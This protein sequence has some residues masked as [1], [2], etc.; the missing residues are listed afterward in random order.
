MN[1]YEI[2]RKDRA[3]SESNAIKILEKGSF[4]TLSTIGADGYPYGIP[5]NYVYNDGKIY[6]HC[7][8]NTG[9]KQDNLRF[10]GK[11]SFSVVTKSEIVPQELT[12]SYESAVVFGTASKI[13]FDKEKALWL[14]A[15]KYSPQ[16]IEES[17]SCIKNEFE[18]TDV[19]MIEI[20]KLTA[21][22]NI[23]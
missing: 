16:F 4:G 18:H 15:K 14:L 8:K 12:T 7:A 6:F 22:S 23:K 5:I 1:H 20:E 9:H 17:E 21:K 11:V 19:F 13:V 3:L 10:S 2:R